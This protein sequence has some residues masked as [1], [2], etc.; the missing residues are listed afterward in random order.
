MTF[1]RLLMVA[2]IYSVIILEVYSG[3]IR[4]PVWWIVP[5]VL[6]ISLVGALVV[7]GDQVAP[8]SGENGHAGAEPTIGRWIVVVVAAT[9]MSG[10]AYYFGREMIPGIMPDA[11]INSAGAG[12]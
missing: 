4:G 11:A 1:L 2:T 8:L 5:G 7:F 12:R 6:V 10:F 9:A 3:V